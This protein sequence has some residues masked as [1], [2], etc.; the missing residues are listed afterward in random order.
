MEDTKKDLS[1]FIKENFN[2][3]EEKANELTELLT[4]LAEEIAQTEIDKWEEYM[5]DPYK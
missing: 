2:L 1:N 5:N 3:T 4:E